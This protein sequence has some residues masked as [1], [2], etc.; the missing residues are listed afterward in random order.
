VKA[1]SL[2]PSNARAYL[3]LGRLHILEEN[4]GKAIEDLDQVIKFDPNNVIALFDLGNVYLAIG[5]RRDAIAAWKKARASSYFVLSGDRELRKGAANSAYELYQLAT[6]IEPSNAK[7][8]VGLGRV[9][10]LQDQLDQALLDFQR[11]VLLDPYN[12]EAHQGLGYAVYLMKGNKAQ[13][14]D[15][16]RIAV[17][18]DPRLYAAYIQLADV[19]QSN[20]EFQEA[21]AVL[22][23]A[24]QLKPNAEE[25]F[26]YLG[27]GYWVKGDCEEAI[28]SLNKAVSLDPN[29]AQSYFLLGECYS[30][31]GQFSEAA[32]KYRTAIS[33]DDYKPWLHLELARAYR[34]SGLLQDAAREY[35]ETM[36]LAPDLS[37][38][39]EELF[40]LERLLPAGSSSGK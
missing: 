31:Q 6:E 34:A 20:G 39:K 15:E 36:R 9:H 22:L 24:S 1:I 8:F 26:Y 30:R 12:A 11:A 18:L 37:G 40:D 14:I 21:E 5:Q 4:Y 38:V 29:R 32:G 10:V 2:H 19:L 33:L 35:S 27:K 13:A 7:G 25:A 17:R 16:L 28:R 3:N 23:D